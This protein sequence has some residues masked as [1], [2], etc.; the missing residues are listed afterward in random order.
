MTDSSVPTPQNPSYIRVSNK[1]R[2]ARSTPPVTPT[3]LIVAPF[4]RIGEGVAN[5]RDGGRNP[6]ELELTVQPANTARPLGATPVLIIPP[7]RLS[8]ASPGGVSRRLP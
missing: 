1:P 5:H 3:I 2:A 4:S 8:S 7:S 6:T